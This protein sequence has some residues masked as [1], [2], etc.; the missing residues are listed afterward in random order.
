MKTKHII[1]SF[2]ILLIT[3]SII[4]DIYAQPVKEYQLVKAIKTDT[5]G[6]INVFLKVDSMQ[7]QHQNGINFS[8]RFKNNFKD[9]IT[10]KN[11]LDFLNIS[12]YN[13]V[14]HDVFIP[15]PSRIMANAKGKDV[16][17]RVYDR[18]CPIVG[19]I[20]NGEAVLLDIE[21]RNIK[22]PGGSNIEIMFRVSE[23][24]PDPVNIND[25]S[26][27]VKLPFDKYR[28]LVSVGII[29]DEERYFHTE[30]GIKTAYSKCN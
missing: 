20:L 19:I 26:L 15:M 27:K 30:G 4:T 24:K 12:L 7:Y 11:P 8:L 17:K 10:I 18:S 2:C 9:S 14:G 16:V 21:A 25:P 22:I 23:V 29:G 6:K 5:V 3:C 13:G 1:N 28:L